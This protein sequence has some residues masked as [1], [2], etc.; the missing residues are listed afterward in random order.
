MA[1]LACFTP[2]SIAECEARKQEL[3]ERRALV[4]Q[5]LEDIGLPVPVR[6]DGAFYVYIDV[7]STGM[8]AMRFCQR[9]LDEARVALTPG[10]D[11][12]ASDARR[13]VRLSYAASQDDLREGLARLKRFVSQTR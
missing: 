9:A 7:S 5:G 6:P 3:A 8:D 4:L 13:Y 12:G 2:E 1:A 11:F 10:H